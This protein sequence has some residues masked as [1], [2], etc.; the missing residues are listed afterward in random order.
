MH[1]FGAGLVVPDIFS[2][3][4]VDGDDALGKEFFAGDFDPGHF[5]VADVRASGAEYDE[6]GGVVIG[7]R[8]PDVAAA[9]F[10]GALAVP[11]LRGHFEFFCF[12][13][14]RG[15][16]WDSP[17]TPDFLA[18]FRV[19][20]GQRAAN[21]I[22]R[23][24]VAH[25]DFSFGDAG[26]AGDAGLCG[27]ANGGFPDLVRGGGIDGA[28][29]AIAGADV[30]LSV[31]DCHA[32]VGARGIG[33]VQSLIQPDLGIVF[34]EQ[35]S[36]DGVDGINFRKWSA[37]VNDAV[38]DDW[39]GN[40]AHCAVVIEIPSQTQVRDIGSVDLLERAEMFRIVGEAV[41]QPVDS[42]G[43]VG[44]D[45]LII[46]IT[47]FSREGRGRLREMQRESS[48]HRENHHRE[49]QNSPCLHV[50]HL[51]PELLCARRSD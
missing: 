10:P 19:V 40:H 4:R 51:S 35:F 12:K 34:P 9:N 15:I 43:C 3:L 49:T 39:F 31:P 50:R 46:H 48:S 7:N 38:D 33:A 28:Q 45:P 1:A 42:R 23:A 21:G 2:G 18:R 20:G 27:L 5:A 16:A 47:G 30:N 26:R 41:H 22:V 14:F 32:A 29:A 37:D 24:V 8:M 6:A 13:R 36:R 17:E 11:G 25:E 44:G